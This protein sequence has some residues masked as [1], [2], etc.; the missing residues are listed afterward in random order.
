MRIRTDENVHF[1]LM[2]VFMTRALKYLYQIIYAYNIFNAIYGYSAFGYV[3]VYKHQEEGR[4]HS[5]IPM[6]SE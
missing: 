4:S 3:C 5:N 1:I 6:H 2:A